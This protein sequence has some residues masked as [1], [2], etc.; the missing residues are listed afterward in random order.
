VSG[1]EGLPPAAWNDTVRA[2]PDV[3]LHEAFE[4]QAGRTPDAPAV[5]FRE[6]VLTYAELEARANQLAGLLIEDGAGAGTLVAV[7]LDRSLE[8]VVSLYAILKAGAAYLPIDPEYPSERITFMLDDAKASILLTHSSLSGRFGDLDAQVMPLDRMA[9]RLAAADAAAAADR[10]RRATSDD[11]AYVI[12]TSGSTGQPK[13]AMIT[14]RA[15]VNRILWMQEYFGL[16]ADDKVLQKTPFSFDVSVWEF[17]WPL[18]FGAELVVAEPGGHRDSGYLAQTIVQRGITTIHF[19]PSMLQLFLEDPRAGDC[20]SLVRV[21]CSGEALPRALQDRF[22]QRSGA[23]L[24]NLYG[25]TEAAVDVTAWACDPAIPLPFVPIGKPVANTQIHILDDDMAPL[26]VGTA[27]ELHIGGVQVGRG[28]LNR[29]ELTAE[30]F[31]DDP[32]RAG[33]V[34]Y[35]TGDLARYLPDGNIEFLGRSDF[36][37]KI[38]GFRVELGEIEAA[39]EAIDSVRQAVVTAHE[40]VDGDLELVAYVAHPQADTLHIDA[41][42]AGLAASLP[43][44]MIP[45]TF[46]P[47]ERFTLTANGKI[48]RKALPAPTRLRPQMDAPYV[49]PRS[50]LERLVADKW[51]AILDLDQVGI[52]DRFFELGGTSLQAARFVNQVQAELDESIFVV[53]LFSAPSVAEYAAFLEREYPAAVARRFGAG[54]ATTAATT[55][56]R[57]IAAS[58][59]ER[60]RSVVPTMAQPTSERGEKNPPLMLI[61][62]PPRSGTT[63]LRIMLAGHRD[64]FA[65]SELQLLG[66]STMR[67]RAAAYSGRFSNWLDGAV[68][69]VMEVEDLNAEEAKAAIAAAEAEGLTTKQFFARLQAAVAPRILVDKSPS[70]A[71]DPA[72]LRKAEVDFESPRYIHLVREPHAMIDSFERHHMEQVLYLDEHGFDSRQ[73]AE[74]VWTLSHRNI[75]DFLADVPTERWHRLRY[76]DLVQDPATQLE[77]LCNG[78]GL[79]FDPAMARPYEMLESKMVDGVYAES[80]PMGDPGFLAHGRIDPALASVRPASD[81]S[82]PLGEPTVELAAR[83]GY[84]RPGSVEADRRERRGSFAQQRDRRRQA[85]GRGRA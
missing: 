29:P 1:R 59:L 16:T 7:C 57:P 64:L 27:G 63:L 11:L 18:L 39:L 53:T 78:L 2:Y 54:V 4:A 15:I 85:R 43:E 24:Y 66:F 82:P 21:V 60:L 31:V 55:E 46:I 77:A 14:H 41:L 25:P 70:Y 6:E 68:R 76:E 81:T 69:T 28:Y 19:V 36:Q 33:G 10:P 3:L 45:T 12:Y 20:A 26:P 71:L 51:R 37:V 23:A 44:Y 61:L 42:R 17:F 34:L 58:D 48:D 22:Y 40:R 5:R 84:G 13:G 47:V 35:K 72:T 67:E 56:R 49:P 83:L 80:A 73:L 38:R 52:H 9:D 75:S 50:E 8:M 74:L 79:V 30:R 32:F 62:S 65:A